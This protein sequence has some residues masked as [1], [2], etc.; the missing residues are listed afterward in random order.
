MATH[1][2]HENEAAQKRQNKRSLV[3]L[4]AKVRTKSES[5]DVK[6]RNLSQKGALLEAESFPPVGTDLVF[7]RGETSVRARVAWEANGRFGIEFLRPIEESEVLIHVG[8]PQ[9]PLPPA[10]VKRSGF[11]SAPLTHGER[12]LAASWVTPVGRT[13]GE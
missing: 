5:F 9:G 13:F 11:R 3:L 6:L 10:S 12:V 4:A 8:R 2:V 1:P 7:E